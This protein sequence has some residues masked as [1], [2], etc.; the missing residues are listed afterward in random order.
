MDHRYHNAQVV[1]VELNMKIQFSTVKTISGSSMIR[2]HFPSFS[3]LQESLSCTIPFHQTQLLLLIFFS[4]ILYN[5]ITI[6]MSIR[7]SWTFYD[8]VTMFRVS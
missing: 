4:K 8:H 2:Q 5:M 3:L 7:L 6:Y 1:T